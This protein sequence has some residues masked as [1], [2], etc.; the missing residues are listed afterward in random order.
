MVE[1]FLPCGWCVGDVC[2][3]ERVLGR[4]SAGVR[5]YVHK[6]MCVCGVC[7]FVRLI[8]ACS[9][10]WCTGG[11]GFVEDVE[12]RCG[13]VLREKKRETEWERKRARKR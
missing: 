10:D 8:F 11:L 13:G 5:T 1:Q 9:C 2:V 7:V 4:G 12:T 6:C 3:C